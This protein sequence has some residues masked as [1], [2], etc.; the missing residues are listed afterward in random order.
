VLTVV[1]IEDLH[2]A[3]EATL[4]MVRL[5]S[6]RLNT[7]QTLIVATYRDDGL[8]P[9]HPMRMAVGELRSER[10]TVHLSLP[11]LS[12][13]AV[14]QL[15]RGSHIAADDLYRLTGGNP[16]FVTEVIAAGDGDAIPQTASEA[17]LS[18]TAR[19]SNAA[20]EVLDLAAVLGARVDVQTLRE[21]APNHGDAI[22]ECLTTGVLVSD[23]D[24]L[25]FRHEIAR[26]AVEAAMSAHRRIDLNARVLNIFRDR[27]EDD[28]RL[29]HHA[30]AAGDR[31][32]TVHYAR[33]AAT[34]ASELG[35]HRESAA[36]WQRAAKYGDDLSA[37]ERAEIYRRLGDEL[38]IIDRWTE[39]AAAL[40]TALGL[41]QDVGDQLRVGDAE[42]AMSKAMFR[43]CKADRS[44]EYA[45]AAVATLEPL[46][47]TPELADAFLN[48]ASFLYDTD[49]QRAIDLARTAQELAKQFGDMRLLSEALNTEGCA[50][51]ALPDETGVEQITAA[52]EVALDGG[53][54]TAAGRAFVNLQV[55]ATN[56]M[57]Y[58]RTERLYEEGGAYMQDHDIG[59][60]AH[61]IAG[62]Q[63]ELLTR[64]G[65]WAEAEAIGAPYLDRVDLSPI[66][67]LSF[68]LAMGTILIRRGEFDAAA[69][70]IAEHETSA[71]GTEE[72]TYMLNSVV[73]RTEA[74]WLAGRSNDAREILTENLAMAADFHDPWARGEIASWLRRF[75]LDDAA[76]GDLAEPYE[77][78]RAGD[79][80]RAGAMLRDIGHPYDAALAFYDSDDEESLR[81]AL[82]TFDALG[83]SAT[84][85]VTAARMRVLGFKSIPRGPRAATRSDAFGLTKREREVLELMCTGA[86][87]GQ[88]A[89]QLF[90]SQRT[91]DHHISSLLMKMDVP[92]RREA[93]KKAQ[94]LQLVG[95][96]TP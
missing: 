20:R 64:L 44:L 1:T 82:A 85:R 3:D 70:L 15:A 77:V 76:L 78:A 30:E 17:V 4:D 5:L 69:P 62:G 37:E 80:A 34:R 11:R 66:N 19:L 8:S 72:P 84:V 22:D 57:D 54:E 86:T 53:L 26:L 10:T 79:P 41:W 65:R 7:T 67:R 33:L 12:E 81:D 35:A 60:Y 6:R 38:A 91:V 88:I 48:R 29:A 16:F 45:E 43:L 73:M 63:T 61:C 75:D 13:H 87:N 96:P 31:T 52:L 24:G 27:L 94:E 42:R 71:A 89:E 18:R 93:A 9:D 68:L 23:T 39:A 32:A 51:E 58:E 59:V 2:W 25:R 90:I 56:A 40:E 92:S 49:T 46:G 55:L 36:Q 50:R 21:L 14:D 47:P 83:A 28:A 74:A 95:A